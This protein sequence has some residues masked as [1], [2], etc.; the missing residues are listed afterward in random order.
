VSK[1]NIIFISALIFSYIGMVLYLSYRYP[2]QSD[3]IIHVLFGIAFIGAAVIGVF[4]SRKF[5][6]TK[7]TLRIIK[8]LFASYAVAFAT[9]MLGSVLLLP[10]VGY[11]GFELLAEPIFGIL[12]LGGAL[13]LTPIVAWKLK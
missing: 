8:V 7:G 4:I 10:L 3:P 5:E 12:L 9:W 13:L 6:K 11:A 2:E 1:R